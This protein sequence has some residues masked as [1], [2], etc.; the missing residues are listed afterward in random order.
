MSKEHIKSI[1]DYVYLTIP[2]QWLPTYHRLLKAVAQYGMDAIKDCSAAC[3][4]NTLKPIQCWNIFQS[5]IAAHAIGDDK[6][7]KLMIDYIDGELDILKI[8]TEVKIF[9]GEDGHIYFSDDSDGENKYFVID[10]FT[11]GL[12]EHF[13]ETDDAKE[14]SIDANGN[15][16]EES[17]N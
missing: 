6:A 7:A 9:I 1:P 12:N 16:I 10:P 11:G 13:T 15:L 5:A 3:K 17:N 2:A 8:D 14:Y 4:E